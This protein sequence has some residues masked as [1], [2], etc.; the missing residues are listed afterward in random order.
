MTSEMVYRCY[1]NIEVEILFCRK[2]Y[3]LHFFALY[4]LQVKSVKLEDS[5]CVGV[6]EN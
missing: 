5:L 3:L 6:S 2:L 1:I 4:L